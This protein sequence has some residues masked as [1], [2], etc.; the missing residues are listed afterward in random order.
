MERQRQGTVILQASI[1][2]LISRAISMALLNPDSV[3][4]DEIVADYK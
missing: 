4:S 1:L 3:A 2:P